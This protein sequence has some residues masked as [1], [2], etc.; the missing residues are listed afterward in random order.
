MPPP[1]PKISSHCEGTKMAESSTER[2]VVT[3][4]SH[5]N[6]LIV[7]SQVV[8]VCVCTSNDKLF[9]VFWLRYCSWGAGWLTP[10]VDSQS[11]KNNGSR[12]LVFPPWVKWLDI[13]KRDYDFESTSLFYEYFQGDFS[14]LT[15]Q[16]P[17][18][19]KP[20][21]WFFVPTKFTDWQRTDL[22]PKGTS[23]TVR[24]TTPT[25]ETYM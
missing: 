11:P 13:E 18:F 8:Y 9:F 20:V 16:G 15:H 10:Y 3:W 17:T 23:G 2:S 24:A 5:S 1:P 21:L 19:K 4:R 12:F 14:I 25:P 7:I 6:I 22:T